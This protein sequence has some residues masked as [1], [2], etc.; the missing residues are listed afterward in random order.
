MGTLSGQAT[1]DQFQS[2]VEMKTF[3]LFLVPSP[4]ETFDGE[5][6]GR[7]LAESPWL[8]Q[9]RSDPTQLIY[10][11]QDNSVR[12]FILLDPGLLEKEPAVEH[13]GY[14]DEEAAEATSVLPD[15]D[16]LEQANLPGAEEEEEEKEQDPVIDMP[17]VSINIP[18]FQ[19]SGVAREAISFL[20][21]IARSAGLDSIDPQAP[22]GGEAGSY[23][24][25]ELYDSWLT[26]QKSVFLELK[27][28]LDFIR[29]S[30]ERS[31]NFFGYAASCPGLREKYREDGLDVL[32][33]Q[34]ASYNGDVLSLCVWRTD[35]PA[36]I[37]LT[38]LVLLE[39][40]RQ[41]RSFFGSRKVTDELLVTGDELWKILEPFSQAIDEPAP[42]LIFREAE[43]PPSQVTNDLEELKGE[44]ATAKRTEF[45]GVI[46]FDLPDAEPEPESSL[47]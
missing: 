42:M 29:W 33:V 41:K 43:L 11:N 15:A 23:S 8:I 17:T 36:V 6:I 3:D 16:D 40:V 44:P 28:E 35:V 39:R 45:D 19:P 7:K 31:R 30:D 20:L 4:S 9:D 38:D 27:G 47:E 12:F 2:P 1:H 24:S 13:D 26:T 14:E 22:G 32:Q 21:S 34:P 18:L 46:D 5:A 37:P 10:H 25:E